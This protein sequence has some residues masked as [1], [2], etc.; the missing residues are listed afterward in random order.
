M[1]HALAILNLATMTSNGKPWRK[2]VHIHL[3]G[4]V[5][6]VPSGTLEIFSETQK[7]PPEVTASTFIYGAKYRE[8]PT[9]IAVDPVSLKLNVANAH[10]GDYLFESAAGDVPLFGA[11]RDAAPDAWGRRVIENKLRADANTLTEGQY[12]E[13]AGANRIGALDFRDKPTSPPK[14]GAIPEA[15]DLRYLLDAAEMVQLGESVPQS[16]ALFFDAAPSMGGARPKAVL[17]DAG[18]QWLAKFPAKDDKFDVPMIEWATLELARKCGLRLPELRLVPLADGRNIMMIERFDRMA[19]QTGGVSRKHVVS[20]LTMLGVHESEMSRSGYAQLAGVINNYGAANF[21]KSDKAELFKR[22]VFNIMVTNDDDHLR[23]HAFVWSGADKGWRLSEL[24]DVLPKSISA[25][26]R[27]QA[28][29]V[30]T[31]GRLATL[32]NALSSAGQFGIVRAEA[33]SLIHEVVSVVREW[34]IHFDEMGVPAAE[35]EKIAPAFRNARDIGLD[36]LDKNKR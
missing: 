4:A 22:M 36:K 33:I 10:T 1:R 19:L 15:K 6:A 17:M 32:D 13:E 5:D 7:L 29:H 24:F 21:V 16:L 11:I 25:H 28:I 18:K 31:Q 34:R 14:Q 9:S 35:T 26:E 3:E 30:G 27:F 12:L 2:V 20:G 23:N 8:R